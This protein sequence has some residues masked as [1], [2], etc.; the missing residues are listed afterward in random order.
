MEINCPSCNEAVLIADEDMAKTFECP[1]C[2]QSLEIDKP[3]PEPVKD[4]PPPVEKPPPVKM[5]PPVSDEAKRVLTSNL[6]ILCPACS[7]AVSK[8]A[9]ICL[10]CGHPIYR[11]ALGKAGASRIINVTILVLL[12]ACVFFCLIANPFIRP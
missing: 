9:D 12:V 5:P 1:F 8:Q 11:G 4:A 7:K 6:L 3:E 10:N 2:Q